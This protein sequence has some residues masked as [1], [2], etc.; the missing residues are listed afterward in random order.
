MSDAIP[1]KLFCYVHPDRETVLRCNRCERPICNE[2]AV[3]TPTGYRCKECVRGQQKIFETAQTSDY[4]L[5]IVIACALGFFG[6]YI[7]R[8][9]SFFIIFIAPVIGVVIAEAV[10]RVTRRRRAKL[11]FQLTAGAAA[12][13]SLPLLLMYVLGAIFSLSAGGFSILGVSLILVWQALY[14]FLVTSTVYYRLSGIR[15]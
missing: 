14:S 4:L 5:S 6:S 2:C 11:L 13:G 9:L 1:P 3:L 10:R 15:M 8:F 12:L 7:A